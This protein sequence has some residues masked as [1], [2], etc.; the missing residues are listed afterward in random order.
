MPSHVL[1]LYGYVGCGKSAIAQ[2]VAENFSKKGRLAASFFFFRATADRS[3][4]ARFAATLASQ[5]A[6]FVPSAR[7]FIEIAQASIGDEL[8]DST[9]ALQFQHLFLEPF[10]SAFQSPGRIVLT[11]VSGP[12]LTVIDGLDECEDREDIAGLVENIIGFFKDKPRT[13]L[14]FFI[15][16]RVEE[17][18]RTR[19]QDPESHVE[20]MDLVAHTSEADIAFLV[21]ESFKNAAKHDRVLQS[22][23]NWP[24]KVRRAKLVQNAD[25][26]FIVISTIL[27]FILEPASDGSTPK[28][29][30]ELILDQKLGL[31]KLYPEILRR[32]ESLDHFQAIITTIAL[33]F[34]PLSTKQLAQI[35][36]IELSDVVSVLINLHSIIHV[37][38]DDIS[39]VTVFH[40]SLREFLCTESRAG[41]YFAS[42]CYHKVLAQGCFK[43]MGRPRGDGTSVVDYAYRFFHRHWDLN[44]GLYRDNFEKLMQELQD[45]IALIRGETVSVPR[46][47]LHRSVAT[48]TLM[49]DLWISKISPRIRK[50]SVGDLVARFVGIQPSGKHWSFVR[51]TFD[52]ISE[53]YRALEKQGVSRPNDELLA[54][55]DGMDSP[56]PIPRIALQHTSMVVACTQLLF[57]HS[58][59]GS[60]AKIALLPLQ[61]QMKPGTEYKA[62]LATCDYAFWSFGLHLA[63]AIKHDPDNVDSRFLT[64]RRKH[65]ET[66]GN[67]MNMIVF[68]YFTAQKRYFEFDS[69]LG[70]PNYLPPFRAN[71]NQATS[72]VES[73]LSVS[74]FLITYTWLLE[75]NLMSAATVARPPRLPER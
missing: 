25:N 55:W 29:R 52:A 16:S 64:T 43:W 5:L 68:N 74:F 57:V 49:D 1:W 53:V 24:D 58:Q 21:D 8:R 10:Y 38:G 63:M 20:L 36:G 60:D 27:K 14:R 37:P 41:P 31:D 40:S 66:S 34:S 54:M 18:I 11:S 50:C 75:A 46:E 70:T 73:V 15:S 12:Y 30:L 6:A 32:S 4:S 33:L 69:L 17:H 39:H 9:V 13:P 59:G 19:L 3:R 26:S 42:P 72:A 48:Y 44:L 7:P 51:T 67:R 22:Y 65:T 47:L 45:F 71:F 56:T 28:T 62:D 23:G 2:T 35:L 61:D